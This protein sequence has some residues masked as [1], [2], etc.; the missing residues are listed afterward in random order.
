MSAVSDK[1]TGP[2]RSAGAHWRN[3]RGGRK[4]GKKTATP[5][6][7]RP[8]PEEQFRIKGWAKMTGDE[9]QLKTQEYFAWALERDL[10][11]ARPFRIDYKG[12][13]VEDRQVISACYGAWKLLRCNA[14][15][16]QDKAKAA[17]S[18]MLREISIGVDSR[19]S[20]QT[21]LVLHSIYRD[22]VA[23]TNTYRRDHLVWDSTDIEEIAFTLDM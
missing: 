19:Q 4:G 13:S 7:V 6:P 2:V 10:N 5:T 9:R 11:P 22:L 16:A 18:K 1:T 15:D 21:F 14:W 23:Q 3:H 20:M 17:F 12:T 8:E